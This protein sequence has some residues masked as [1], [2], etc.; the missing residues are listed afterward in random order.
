MLLDQSAH[1]NADVI[2]PEKNAQYSLPETKMK[3]TDGEKPPG[4]PG[5]CGKTMI[6]NFNFFHRLVLK[7][8]IYI[9]INIQFCFKISILKYSGI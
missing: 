6:F 3:K 2:R 7:Y 4:E 9:T 1:I 5:K 8:L